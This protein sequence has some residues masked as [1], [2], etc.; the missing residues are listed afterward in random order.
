MQQVI[1]LHFDI[2]WTLAIVEFMLINIS[3]GNCLISFWSTLLPLY[4]L[5]RKLPDLVLCSLSISFLRKDKRSFQYSKELNKSKC[6]FLTKYKTVRVFFYFV[7][8]GVLFWLIWSFDHPPSSI[9][10]ENI[11]SNYFSIFVIL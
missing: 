1:S 6:I 3:N 9:A 5:T 11:L 8:E 2:A 10:A 4:H 7:L